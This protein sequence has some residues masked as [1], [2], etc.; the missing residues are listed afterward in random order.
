MATPQQ[1]HAPRLQWLC[2]EVNL[3][4]R[5]DQG[6]SV[7]WPFNSSR[8]TDWSYLPCPAAWFQK[9][10]GVGVGPLSATTSQGDP[11]K[12]AAALRSGAE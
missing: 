2:A 8:L 10:L 1:C 11:V 5:G 3:W 4:R 6:G 7:T 12:A 9:Q